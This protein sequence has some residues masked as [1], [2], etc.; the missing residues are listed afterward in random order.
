MDKKP[1]G[2]GLK[3]LIPDQT[4]KKEA[5][6]PAAKQEAK[7]TSINNASTLSDKATP[8]E[9]DI[10]VL[11]TASTVSEPDPLFVENLK[12]ERERRVKAIEAM[13]ELIEKY[14]Q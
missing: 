14:S 5:A 9:G 2:K 3:A 8:G 4:G 10:K 13:N 11:G 12:K 7:D 6:V 1:I